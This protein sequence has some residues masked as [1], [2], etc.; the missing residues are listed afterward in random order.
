MEIGGISFCVDQ[1][2]ETFF[3][4]DTKRKRAFKKVDSDRSFSFWE[5]LALVCP[6]AGE[7]FNLGRLNSRICESEPASVLERPAVSR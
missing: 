3:Q 4:Q 7:F 6:L 5:D 2:C 1:G